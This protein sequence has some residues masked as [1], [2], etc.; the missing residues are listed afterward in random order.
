[1]R[2]SQARRTRVKCASTDGSPYYA[3]LLRSCPL[4]SIAVKMHRRFYCSCRS[5][6]GHVPA[7]CI[8][9]RDIKAV[10]ITAAGSQC[11]KRALAPLGLTSPSGT[12]HQ[13]HL[14]RLWRT[15]QVARTRQVARR[16]FPLFPTRHHCNARKPGNLPEAGKMASSQPSPRRPEVARVV[17]YPSQPRTH[18]HTHAYHGS[19][20]LW[21]FVLHLHSAY[22]H[23]CPCINFGSL[24]VP[25]VAPTRRLPC[26]PR[27][28]A[29]AAAAAAAW[30]QPAPS[31]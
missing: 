12:P 2:A 4:L 14:T 18:T 26:A 22:P 17:R 9:A 21:K 16:L 23:D 20:T 5:T 27:A 29:G 1:M 8:H 19:L 6:R 15:T 10:F 11:R 13:L 28:P 30:R 7:I 25:A 3:S 31:Q 24:P